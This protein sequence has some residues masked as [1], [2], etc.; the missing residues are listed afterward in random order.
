MKT[1][2]K[3]LLLAASF[4]AASQLAVA[5]G[6]NTAPYTGMWEGEYSYMSSTGRKDVP[7]QLEL[8]QHKGTSLAGKISEPSSF[9]DGTSSSLRADVV[10]IVEGRRM[11]LVKTYDGTAN[12]THSVYYEGILDP[13]S[14]TV[15]GNWI[16][17]DE[18]NGQ[19]RATKR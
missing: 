13:V 8:R 6:A 7:F 17:S 4:L 15:S 19:F 18:W 12:Q 5:Q 1:E 10:G 9:G 16:I 2:W 11:R 3:Q 14:Q